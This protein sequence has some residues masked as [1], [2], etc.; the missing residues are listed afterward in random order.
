MTGVFLCH[1]HLDKPFVKRVASSLTEIGTKVWIDEAEIRVGDVLIDKISNAINTFDFL[2]AFLSPNSV[3]SSWVQYEL[4]LAMTKEINGKRVV[5]LPI[6]LPGCKTEDIPHSINHKLCADFREE[7]NYDTALSSVL[8][9]IKADFKA[10]DTQILGHLKN[11][12]M[13]LCPSCHRTSASGSRHCASCG[14]SFQNFFANTNP[15]SCPFCNQLR[16]EIFSTHCEHCGKPLSLGVRRTLAM[17]ALLETENQTRIRIC[18]QV[19]KNGYVLDD[20]ENLYLFDIVSCSIVSILELHSGRILAIAD[21]IGRYDCN[22][23][24][25]TE[26]EYLMIN[27]G[28]SWSDQYKPGFQVKGRFPLNV[29]NVASAA[30]TDLLGIFPVGTVTGKLVTIDHG[31]GKVDEII[32]TK[33]KEERLPVQSIDCIATNTD[34]PEVV[35][36]AS[37]DT[38]LATLFDIANP[39]KI[40][41]IF[42]GPEPKDCGFQDGSVWHFAVLSREAIKVCSI[43]GFRDGKIRET[44]KLRS[45]SPFTTFFFDKS[46]IIFTGHSSGALCIWKKENSKYLKESEL[47]GHL[48]EVSCIRRSKGGMLVSCAKGE[49]ALWNL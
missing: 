18:K 14:F 25:C 26:S 31:T 43:E 20:S 5:V 13:I 42:I 16:S 35:C 8:K 29:G 30:F 6:L 33:D 28:Y 23:F 22:V 9:A 11:L 1:N 21:A 36:I 19:N 40:A 37:D 48:S 45:D 24:V 7:N 3:K 17:P 34:D 44:D 12:S 39:R 47:F 41:E 46:G 27:H 2:L 32:N 4:A 15:Y 38:G 10:L 49:I